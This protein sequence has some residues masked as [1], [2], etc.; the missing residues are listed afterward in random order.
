LLFYSQLEEAATAEF[1]SFLK[2]SELVLSSVDTDLLSLKDYLE[3]WRIQIWDNGF[4]N[5]FRG[6]T[7]FIK[8]SVFA[9]FPGTQQAVQRLLYRFVL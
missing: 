4:F 3:K 8:F 5:F 2:N 6:K 7:P 9:E 1:D